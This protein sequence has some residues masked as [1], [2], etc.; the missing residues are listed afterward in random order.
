MHKSSRFI[1]L[2]LYFFNVEKVKAAREKLPR[3][4]VG[5]NEDKKNEKK[6]KKEKENNDIPS[7]YS[8]LVTEDEPVP[9]YRGPSSCPSNAF[10]YGYSNLRRMMLDIAS[11]N[12][13]NPFNI[14]PGTVFN[15]REDLE[16]DGKVGIPLIIPF[17]NVTINCGEDG[18][19][20]DKCIL[21]GGLIQVALS[22]KNIILNGLRFTGSAGISVLGAGS[23]DSFAIFNNCTWK[24]HTGYS[25]VYS[26]YLNKKV[27]EDSITDPEILEDFMIDEGETPVGASVKGSGMKL[28]FNN[29]DFKENKF[30]SVVMHTKRSALRLSS[31]MFQENNGDMADIILAYGSDL[32]IKDSCFINEGDKLLGNIYV[33]DDSSLQAMDNYATGTAG[34]FSCDSILYSDFRCVSFSGSSCAVDPAYYDDDTEE[35]QNQII[36]YNAIRGPQ[37]CSTGSNVTGYTNLRRMLL[38]METYNAS[39][40]LKEQTFNL[41]PDT[42]YNISTDIENMDGD[43]PI[44][45]PFDNVLL[46]CGVDGSLDNNCVLSGGLTHLILSGSNITINGLTF[47]ESEGVSVMALGSSSSSAAFND[48]HWMNNKGYAA[49][50]SKFNDKNL[51]VKAISDPEA[52]DNLLIDQGEVIAKY[53]AYA[54]DAENEPGMQLRFSNCKYTDNIYLSAGVIQSVSSRIILMGAIFENNKIMKADV[55][56]DK[57]STSYITDTCFYKGTRIYGNIYVSDDSTFYQSNN[58]AEDT[59]TQYGCDDIFQVVNDPDCV[60]DKCRT[61]SCMSFDSKYCVPTKAN[62]VP[63]ASNDVYNVIFKGPGPCESNVNETGYDNLRRLINDIDFLNSTNS[64]QL[65]TATFNLCSNTVYRISEDMAEDP[66]AEL[67]L[68]I[69]FDDVTINCGA[70]GSLENKCIIFGGM[71]QL[72]VSGKNIA[73]NGITFRGSKGLSIMAIG[74]SS[75]NVVFNNCNWIKNKGN[76]VVFAQ[77]DSSNLLEASIRDLDSLD[78]LILDKNEQLQIPNI[79]DAG[80]ILTFY[81]CSFLE[82]PAKNSLIYSGHSTIIMDNTDFYRNYPQDAEIILSN[83]SLAA[84]KNSCFYNQSSYYG[85][86]FVSSD[87]TILSKHNYGDIVKGENEFGCNHIF[88]EGSNSTYQCANFSEPMCR[89]DTVDDSDSASAPSTMSPSNKPEYIPPQPELVSSAACGLSLTIKT[90]LVTLFLSIYL[91][92]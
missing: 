3:A 85:Q 52:L 49:V 43:T 29:C 11:G 26:Q 68:L 50:Y 90:A 67:P 74:D 7:Y 21:D 64:S 32:K 55:I 47:Q 44:L 23:S 77:Y 78:E 10:Q 14:C 4:L 62:K 9:I 20:S 2:I 75:K 63:K 81:N 37:V 82:N 54:N 79:E 60:G 6:Q 1:L 27:L 87:S 12:T 59:T 51:L 30:S 76:T 88:E 84:I 56:L 65:S 33:S 80:M 72:I 70:D 38:D 40:S 71:A 24:N 18:S 39:S 42:V 31:V 35:T 25:A 5:D 92:I 34:G 46:N 8:V 61:S 41:C 16:A 17:D 48:C 53:A 89:S 13:Q 91:E 57:K 86:I 22:G 19:L 66:D 83:S 36:S 15:I 28:S 73:I 69:P 58:Y 45:L